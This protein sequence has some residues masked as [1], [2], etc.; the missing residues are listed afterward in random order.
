MNRH[1]RLPECVFT[2]PGDI[3]KNISSLFLGS[4]HVYKGH[5][6]LL[7]YKFAAFVVTVPLILFWKCK[8][9]I[10]CPHALIV[11]SALPGSGRTRHTLAQDSIWYASSNFLSKVD[12]PLICSDVIAFPF[13]SEFQPPG[14]KA[15]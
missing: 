4:K 9:S 8:G 5:F 15:I 1:T 10:K 3:L 11:C 7:L 2:R 6:V 13:M 12:E 14:K